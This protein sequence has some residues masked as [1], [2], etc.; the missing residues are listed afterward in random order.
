MEIHKIIPGLPI[1]A[2]EVGAPYPVTLTNNVSNYTIYNITAGRKL[3]LATIIATNK[4]SNATITVF[5]SSSTLSNRIIQLVI[6]AEKSE[7]LGPEDLIGVKEA[8]SSIV[9]G[10]TVSGV[11]VHVGGFEY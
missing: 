3:K 8:I 6:G 4:S 2:I 9:I 11:V 5:D 10:S 1:P 7:I